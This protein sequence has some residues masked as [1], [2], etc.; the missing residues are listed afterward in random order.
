MVKIGNAANDE[1]G[2]S[3]GGKAGDQTGKEVYI[4]DWYNRSKGWSHI[5]R[6]KSADVAEKIAIAMEQ[7]C[8]N[9]KI[10][11]DQNQRTTLYFQAR[12]CAWDLSKIDVACETDCSA[13]VAVCVNA[14]GIEV[15]KDMYTGN[16]VEVLGATGKFEI[17]TDSDMLKTSAFLKRGDI[18]LG[19][20][21][22]AVVLSDG[23]RVKFCTVT[24]RELQK[25]DKGTNVKA[26][27]ILLAGK[28]FNPNGIDGI[29]GS[30]CVSAVK[31]Y[32]KSKGLT[33]DGIVG[34]K[35]WEALLEE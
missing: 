5:I 10:G 12:N 28:G 25:G 13:L 32:Q 6:P 4:R 20:G 7:A 15:S 1:N 26:L 30:G 11:Y 27:Q 3:K 18:I 33:I 19:T 16:Q 17:I 21:H 29:F 35:T 23:D 34:K 24:L 31:L 14:A 22:T 9:D 2:K 8:Q